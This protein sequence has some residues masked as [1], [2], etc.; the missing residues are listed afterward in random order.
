MAFPFKPSEALTDDQLKRGLNALT[1]QT[2]AASGANSQ[3]AVRGAVYGAIHGANNT[4]LEM[5]SV[6]TD[7]IEAARQAA[8]G[9]GISEQEAIGYATQAAMEAAEGLTEEPRS[10]IRE[11]VLD[12]LMEEAAASEQAAPTDG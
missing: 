5:G 3:D 4:G 10:Q 6:V 2:I 11:A 1:F 9:L 12:E 7:S 8:P